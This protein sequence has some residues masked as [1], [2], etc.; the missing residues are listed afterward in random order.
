[1]PPTANQNAKP[2]T[3][4][5]IRI[6]ISG[7]EGFQQESDADWRLPA[8]LKVSSGIQLRIQIKGFRQDQRLAAAF[9]QPGP[10]SAKARSDPNVNPNPIAM[11]S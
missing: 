11:A 4:G 8:G 10:E 5:G 7:I 6:R 2:N 1:M 3:V 9:G